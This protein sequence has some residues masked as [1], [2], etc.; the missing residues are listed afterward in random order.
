MA[1]ACT[2]QFDT[3]VYKGAVAFPTQL[4]INGEFVDPI[5]KGTIE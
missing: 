5:N 1:S 3:A 4:F 2:Y